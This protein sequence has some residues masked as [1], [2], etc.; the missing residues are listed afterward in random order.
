MADVVD[1]DYMTLK[2]AYARAKEVN[3][4]KEHKAKEELISKILN[5][6]INCNAKKIEI[7]SSEYCFVFN[8]GRGY[9]IQRKGKNKLNQADPDKAESIRKREK[10]AWDIAYDSE[11]R[12][13]SGFRVVRGEEEIFVFSDFSK[14]EESYDFGAKIPLRHVRISDDWQS[15]YIS[16]YKKADDIDVD[17]DCDGDRL[18]FSKYWRNATFLE[19]IAESVMCKRSDIE[20][21]FSFSIDSPKRKSRGPSRARRDSGLI[22][23]RK[24]FG[25][26]DGKTSKNVFFI[27]LENFYDESFGAEKTPSK[28]TL[29]EIID[30]WQNSATQNS[31]I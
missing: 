3:Q 11:A 17:G 1:D 2:S 9:K 24:E 21:Y 16:Q 4:N 30:E 31:E 7:T 29:Y 6:K 14:E 15:I 22:F 18:K 5:K 23:L 12:I 19:V 25:S 28:S 8:V 26:F 20:M 27:A 10:E 13:P